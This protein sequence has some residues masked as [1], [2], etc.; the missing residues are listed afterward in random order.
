MISDGCCW[1]LH[2]AAVRWPGGSVSLAR[3]AAPGPGPPRAGC[4]GGCCQPCPCARGTAEWRRA[5][6]ATVHRRPGVQTGRTFRASAPFQQRQ[7]LAS[8]RRARRRCNVAVPRNGDATEYPAAAGDRPCQAGASTVTDSIGPGPAG[9][10]PG[11]RC[12]GSNAPSRNQ[13]CRYSGLPP[14]PT[15]SRCM[16]R[17][18][19]LRSTPRIWAARVLLPPAWRRASRIWT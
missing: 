8:E 15:P 6:R 1:V 11:C 4:P 19:V 10:Q 7:W 14:Q 13:T 18:S 5:Q 3:P 17:H 2:L 16:R 9:A 12:P